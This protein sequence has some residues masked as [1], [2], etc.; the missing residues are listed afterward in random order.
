[1]YYITN[2]DGRLDIKKIGCIEILKN[3][4]TKYIKICFVHYQIKILLRMK[5]KLCVISWKMEIY[6]IQFI[7]TFT[8]LFYVQSSSI[9]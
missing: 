7:M 5:K 4:L 1:M 3:L 8:V 2:N 6:T 9:H